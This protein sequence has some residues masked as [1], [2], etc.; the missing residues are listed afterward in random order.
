MTLTIQAHPDLT[1]SPA[2]PQ[3]WTNNWV[4]EI[5]MDVAS[6]LAEPSRRHWLAA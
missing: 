5:E 1:T 4:K 3:A 2:V 6:I